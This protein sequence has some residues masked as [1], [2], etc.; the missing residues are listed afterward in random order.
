ML[1]IGDVTGGLIHK[2]KKDVAKQHFEDQKVCSEG[3]S[4]RPTRT[5]GTLTQH[6]E[7]TETCAMLRVL[8]AGA[9]KG[10]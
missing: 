5:F 10:H 3:S 4:L 9:H 7:E 2:P 8:C 6:E 1:K